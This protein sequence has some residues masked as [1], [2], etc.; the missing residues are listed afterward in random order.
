MAGCG[1][2]APGGALTVKNVPP[3]RAS[4]I[5]VILMEN[6]E[7]TAVLGSSSAPYVNGL[8]RRYGLATQSFAITHPSLPNYLALTSGSTHGITSDCTS[9]TVAAPN[10]VDQLSAAGISWR[11]YLEDVPS[12]CWRG[13]DAGGY[14]KRHN[15]FIYY[16]DVSGRAA[17]CRQLVGFDRLASDLRS[18]TLPTFAWITPNVC[19]DTH[20][21]GVAA[22][23]RFLA[24]T[25]PT[26]LRAL[27][28]SG[29]LIL[30]WDEGDSNAGCCGGVA[31]GGHIPTIVAGPGVRPD[32][33][34]SQ[35]VDHYGVL[36]TIEDALGLAPLG[37]AGDSRNGTLDP[38]FTRPPRIRAG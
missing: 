36:R 23:D 3:S 38:L 37:A 5:V 34:D 24:R 28:P 6:K 15:P 31:A 9:C 19:D 1:S 2:A 11:A 20:D 18:G 13:G 8:A 17:R 29:F 27:G 12:P 26:L 16:D 33:Q 7:S 25:V 10:L 32:A 4:H 21:C 35:P 14:A 22:G 30:T